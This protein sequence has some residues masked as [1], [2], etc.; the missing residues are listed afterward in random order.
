MRSFY[1]T[2][3]SPDLCNK[4]SRRS[5]GNENRDR[6]HNLKKCSHICSHDGNIDFRNQA[7]ARRFA[8][9]L[10]SASRS[11][12]RRFANVRIPLKKPRQSGLF[13]LL[14]FAKVRGLPQVSGTHLG[15]HSTLAGVCVYLKQCR[16]YI[17]HGLF[18][19][20]GDFSTEDSVA[21]FSSLWFCRLSNALPPLFL[22]S[23][24]LWCPNLLV[25]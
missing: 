4:A 24:G 25:Q 18:F 21:S 23:T 19:E 20:G 7:M 12:S 1:R 14:G 15:T 16:Y 10:A 9:S 5:K 6:Q 22:S 3:A 17:L 13:R 11:C 2:D 8:C